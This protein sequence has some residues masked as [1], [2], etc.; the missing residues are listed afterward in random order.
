M[1]EIILKKQEC[2]PGL[3]LDLRRQLRKRLS[4]AG[5]STMLQGLF[6]AFQESFHGVKGFIITGC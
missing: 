2:F 5:R 4:E 3:L 6:Q 1:G